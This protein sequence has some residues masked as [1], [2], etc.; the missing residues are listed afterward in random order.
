MSRPTLNRVCLG[1]LLAGFASTASADDAPEPRAACDLTCTANITAYTDPGQ[2]TATIAYSQPTFTGNCVDSMCLPGSGTAFALG[3]T[4]VTCAQPVGEYCTFTIT[5]HDAEVPT[6]TVPAPNSVTTQ[7]DA[8][9]APL[10]PDLV[11]LSTAT[12][13]C[14]GPVT[15]TQDPPA[16]TAYEAGR[17]ISPIVVAITAT[18]VAGNSTTGGYSLSVEPRCGCGICGVGIPVNLTGVSL[19][20]V[21]QKGLRRTRRRR[22]QRLARHQHFS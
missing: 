1:L 18:D 22:S 16:N 7:F 2:C 19:A 4:T 13:N 9:C 20:L 8:T 10:I 12:D 21:A 3:E 5:V 15:I 11:A 14:T 6:L 17:N